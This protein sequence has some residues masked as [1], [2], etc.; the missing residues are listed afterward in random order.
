MFTRLDYAGLLMELGYVDKQIFFHTE[1][2]GLHN[3]ERF[4]TN[5]EHRKNR[6]IADIKRYFPKGYKLLKMAAKA[7][8]K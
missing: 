3:L 4:I 2:D 1:C 6:K 7:A 8:I 5:F